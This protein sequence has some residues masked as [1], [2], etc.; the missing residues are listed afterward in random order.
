MSRRKYSWW[1]RMGWKIKDIKDDIEILS[2]TI[3]RRIRYH[4]FSTHRLLVLQNI[5][6]NKYYDVDILLIECV[7]QL[8][9]NFVENEK[10]HMAKI[11]FVSDYEDYLKGERSITDLNKWDTHQ[12]VKDYYHSSWWDKFINEEKWNRKLGE[13]YLLCEID[14]KNDTYRY[15]DERFMNERQAAHAQEVLELYRY[16]KER[17]TRLNPFDAFESPPDQFHFIHEKG[18]FT[19]EMLEDEPSGPN[20]TAYRVREFSPEYAEYLK[21]CSELE[22]AQY[23]KDTEMAQRVLKI[24][25][26]LW[27]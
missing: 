19:D 27:T 3:Y 9:I 21:K 25:Q 24:R 12:I 26:G 18:G 10:A 23:E 4:W 14:M 20:L 5:P 22:D 16:F 2:R 7:S 6:A 11:C 17:L 1:T 13:L 15:E 8:L